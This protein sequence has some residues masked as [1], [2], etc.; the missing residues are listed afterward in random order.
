MDWALKEK[1]DHDKTI[2]RAIEK[3]TEKNAQALE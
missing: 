2:R 1:Q 3:Q